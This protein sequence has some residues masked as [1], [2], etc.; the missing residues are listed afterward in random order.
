MY[1]GLGRP[2][3]EICNNSSIH[4]PVHVRAANCLFSLSPYSN[5][6]GLLKGA[7]L[8]SQG[9][10]VYVRALG[11]TC[12]A[13]L[14][15]RP[16]V[17][18]CLTPPSVLALETHQEKLNLWVCSCRKRER[19]GENEGERESYAF[20]V[21]AKRVIGLQ[22]LS[23]LDLVFLPGARSLPPALTASLP[24]LGSTRGWAVSRRLLN[25]SGWQLCPI[26]E[27]IYFKQDVCVESI[28]K[29]ITG[30]G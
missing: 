4:H 29:H 21:L 23:D 25:F 22:E 1:V 14:S 9:L 19:E 27:E 30:F 28:D 26:K 2:G 6:S 10:A 18:Q 12:L 11:P 16:S 3:C 5:Y 15:G 24:G 8:Q 7:V 13:P 17:S 20:C